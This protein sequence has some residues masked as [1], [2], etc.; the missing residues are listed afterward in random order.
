M[1]VARTVNAPV[2][3]PAF[4]TGAVAVPSVPVATLTVF[5]PPSNAA[6]VSPATVKVTDTLASGLPKLLFARTLI[7]SAKASPAVA[8]SSPVPAFCTAAR[9]GVGVGSGVGVGVVG[10][11]GPPGSEGVGLGF[12][13]GLGV[14]VGDGEPEGE[15][16]GEEDGE[17][18]GLLPCVP[19]PVPGCVP[20]L[21]STGRTPVPSG[22]SCVPRL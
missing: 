1:A 19:E 17:E 9:A 4:S 13:G 20:V 5:F 2:F 16:D 11:P 6:S 10:V 15:D 18:D 3:S 8:D 7:R 12:D 14:G 22:T 21:D